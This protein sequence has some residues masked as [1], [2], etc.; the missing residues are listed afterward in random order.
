MRRLVPAESSELEDIL[1]RD[2]NIPHAGT[3]LL[4]IAAQTGGGSRAEKEAIE[5][6]DRAQVAA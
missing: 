2:G 3:A 5:S 4:L 1:G 6:L